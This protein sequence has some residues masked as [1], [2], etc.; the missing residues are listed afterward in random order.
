MNI[1]NLERVNTLV[2]IKARCNRALSQLEEYTEHLLANPDSGGIDGYELGYYSILASYD[3]G[4]GDCAD[5]TGCYVG[6]QMA[7]ATRTILQN[8]ILRIDSNLKELGVIF[9]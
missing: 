7:D 6:A 1:T 4:S 9:D 8:Q 2:K 5:M 3:D